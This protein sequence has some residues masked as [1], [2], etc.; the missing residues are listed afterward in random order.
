ML[1]E[2]TEAVQRVFGLV[3]EEATFAFGEPAEKT[4][5]ARPKRWCIHAGMG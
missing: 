2:A 5:L 1:A 3:L 4:A